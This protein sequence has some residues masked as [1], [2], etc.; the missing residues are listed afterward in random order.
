MKKQYNIPT[1][2]YGKA[3]LLS[4]LLRGETTIEDLKAENSEEIFIQ[5]NT[6]DGDSLI[7]SGE[8][9]FTEEQ[10]Q[11]YIH[12]PK[13]R[14]KKFHRIQIIDD[15]ESIPPEVQKRQDDWEKLFPGIPY[16]SQP[17]CFQ[18]GELSKTLQ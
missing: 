9:T 10:Y 6:A 18:F 17:Q 7:K 14:N 11:E 12:L 1:T 8:K 2:K 3:Q 16:G 4:G 15:T 13:N 5:D